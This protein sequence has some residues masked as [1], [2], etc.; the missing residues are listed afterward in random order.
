MK[1][2]TIESLLQ[3]ADTKKYQIKDIP[4]SYMADALKMV[5]IL[6]K[7]QD[8]YKKELKPT[9]FY[10]DEWHNAKIGGAKNSNHKYCLAVDISDPKNELF[11]W[12]TK[13]NQK[14]ANE[15]NIWIENIVKKD[16]SKRNWV[17]I[18]TKPFS[19]Y[20]T[21]GNRVFEP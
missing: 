18:A 12:L 9:C 4:L 21:G 5:T 20:K 8:D 10:R 13:D 14:K 19:S 2:V 3:S 6:N 1:L 11:D 16:G 17:H 15:Y 7:I